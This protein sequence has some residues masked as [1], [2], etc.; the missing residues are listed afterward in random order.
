MALVKDFNRVLYIEPNYNEKAYEKI[1]TRYWTHDYEDYCVCVD[2]MVEVSDRVVDGKQTNGNTTYIFSWKTN[3]ERETKSFM[4]GKNYKFDDGSNDFNV[5]TTHY[6]DTFYGDVLEDNTLKQTSNCEL[7][8]INSIDISYDAY[9]VPQVTIKFTD[10]RGISLF[11]PEELRHRKSENGVGGF[12][13]NDVAGSFFKCFFTFP[14]PKFTILIKGFYGEPITYELT[15]AKFIANFDSKTGNFGATA[16]LVGYSFSLLNDVSFNALLAAPLSDYIGEKYWNERVKQ[17]VFSITKKDESGALTRVEM[18]TFN[19]IMKS[20]QNLKGESNAS[21]EANKQYYDNQAQASEKLNKIEQIYLEYNNVYEHYLSAVSTD[22]NDAGLFEAIKNRQKRGFLYFTNVENWKAAEYSGDALKNIK[23]LLNDLGENSESVKINPPTSVQTIMSIGNTSIQ[24]YFAHLEEAKR[25]L[26]NFK[27]TIFAQLLACVNA[28]NEKHEETDFYNVLKTRR[29]SILFDP[30]DFLNYIDALK[31]KYEAQKEEADKVIAEVESKV[32]EDVLGFTPSVKNVMKITMAHLET[33]LHMMY[34]TSRR[35]A[36]TPRT[37]S[38]LGVMD[39]NLIGL[40]LD[41]DNNVGAWPKITKKNPKTHVFEDAWIGDFPKNGHM[42]PEAMMVCGL[43]N[44]VEAMQQTI[45]ELAELQAIQDR[46]NES[47]QTS[48]FSRVGLPTTVTDLCYEGNPFGTNDLQKEKQV[49]GIIEKMF[50]RLYNSLYLDSKNK[51]STDK[52]IK[53]FGNIDAMNFYKRYKNSIDLETKEK[54]KGL[55]IE[56]F[57]NI[58]L[59]N[60]NKYKV[61]IN[62]LSLYNGTKQNIVNSLSEIGKFPM[63]NVSFQDTINNNIDNNNLFI[64][65]KKCLVENY[66]KSI[67]YTDKVRRYNNLKIDET[68]LKQKNIA[69]SSEDYKNNV[70]DVVYKDIVFDQEKLYDGNKHFR[71]RSSISNLN[72]NSFG[73]KFTASK[74]W[75]ENHSVSDE[76]EI[77]LDNKGETT[78]SGLISLEPSV[79]D[80]YS[81]PANVHRLFNLNESGAIKVAACKEDGDTRWK[82]IDRDNFT[83]SELANIQNIET[84]NEIETNYTIPTLVWYSNANTTNPNNKKSV[85]AVKDYYQNDNIIRTLLVLDNFHDHNPFALFDDLWDNKKQFIYTTEVNT[86]ILGGYFYV[87]ENYTDNN[88][89][90]KISPDGSIEHINGGALTSKNFTVSNIKDK[91]NTYT[92]KYFIDKFLDWQKQNYTELIKPLEVINGKEKLNDFINF[93]TTDEGSKGKT[94]DEFINR[95]H[96]VRIDENLTMLFRETSDVIKKLT[97]LYIKPC[98]LIK[99]LVN[100]INTDNKHKENWNQMSVYIEGFYDELKSLFNNDINDAY[101]DE[102]ITEPSDPNTPKEIKIGIY[103]YLKI[104]Y[105]KWLG[106]TKEDEWTIENFFDKHF[107]FI[108]SFYNVIGDEAPINPDKMSRLIVRS[109]QDEKYT[110]ISFVTSVLQENNLMFHCIQNFFDLNNDTYVEGMK[111]MFEPIPYLEMERP[112]SIPHFVVM[113]HGEPSAHLNINGGDYKDDSFLLSDE[114]FMPEALTSVPSS[115]NALKIP[116]FGV[117]YGSQYQSYFTD[118]SVGMDSNAVTEQSLQA[119]MMIAGMNSRE[120]ENGQAVYCLGQDLYTVYANQ[121]YTCNV[122]MMGCAWVQPLMYFVLT[123]IPLF[124]GSYQ[125]TKVTHDISQGKMTTQFTGVRMSNTLTP[126]VKNIYNARS[127]RN[128]GIGNENGTLEEGGEANINSSCPY[129]VYG[130]TS[131]KGGAPIEI[132]TEQG[133]YQKYAYHEQTKDTNP[134]R[135]N[136]ILDGLAKTILNECGASDE[137]H[138]Y[139]IATVL[140]NRYKNLNQDFKKL[141]TIGQIAYDVERAHSDNDMKKAKEIALDIFSNT[142]AILVGK[143]TKPKT[144]VSV[145]IHGVLQNYKTKS[146]KLTMDMLQKAYMYCTEMGYDISN[147]RPD[148][149]G[150]LNSK[151]QPYL[152]KEPKYWRNQTYLFHHEGHVFTSGDKD[153]SYWEYTPKIDN[154]VEEN[155]LSTLSN[156]FLNA[157]QKTINTSNFIDCV[158]VGQPFNGNPNMIKITTKDK[159]K[160]EYLSSVFDIILNGYGKYVE[161]LKWCCNN[162]NDLH[163]NIYPSYVLVTVVENEAANKQIWLSYG[164]IPTNLDKITSNINVNFFKSLSKYYDVSTEEGLGEIKMDCKQFNGCSDDEI[165]NMILNAK[166]LD[167]GGVQ[168]SNSIDNTNIDFSNVNISCV[169]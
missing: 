40:R 51:P 148:A 111:K 113:Y 149:L 11:S 45:D 169:I 46:E 88:P 6:T 48:Y 68:Y 35:V 107:T 49:E 14:Y 19:M 1:G 84:S 97:K 59:G 33:L 163:S 86:L 95:K 126:F 50:Y 18:P 162:S 26:V 69:D 62:N 133:G 123:N 63:M 167:C 151:G 142:P 8:G 157:V 147:P 61:R 150:P 66:D 2:L 132:L 28:I 155:G 114:M 131:N 101:T 106:A 94:I 9:C 109:G 143:E 120:G 34:Q 92:K 75:T 85:F 135:F 161:D 64:N 79:N 31:D 125:I 17:G 23:K 115:E 118:V 160:E 128:I 165:R 152:E 22:R 77:I 137:L 100:S 10:I 67:I 144:N 108:D 57:K 81:F 30:T 122:T 145:Y 27:D 78:K 74:D 76:Y 71:H 154:G 129:R 37:P 83:Y 24:C 121:S 3:N 140:F 42:Q 134:N 60:S 44:G 73:K 119:Q 7:F 47:S 89:I 4:S 130:I 16:K 159:D 136:T 25:T 102:E 153:K 32:L 99:P 12:A 156:S 38:E 93:V 110:L 141:F 55:S 43:Q 70:I 52:K 36:E 96:Y 164:N 65:P 158:I 21:K 54:I 72:Y 90:F 168:P 166:A 98:L 104:L 103:K 20:I 91:L 58:I 124:R 15:C 146:T 87:L 29:Y 127:D 39:E 5:L 41:G 56:D 105:D 53:T 112:E 139:L 82:I 13:D 80:K 138:M 117:S 116:A